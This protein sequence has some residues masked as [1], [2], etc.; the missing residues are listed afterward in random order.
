MKYPKLI[1]DLTGDAPVGFSEA[2]ALQN[3]GA[4]FLTVSGPGFVARKQGQ[5]LNVTTEQPAATDFK[6]YLW[7][8]YNTA[9]VDTAHP[10]APANLHYVVADPKKRKRKTLIGAAPAGF[11]VSTAGL[12]VGGGKIAMLRYLDSSA[13]PIPLT[14]WMPVATEKSA[15]EESTGSG[16]GFARTMFATGWDASSNSWRYGFSTR[17]VMDFSPP[18]AAELQMNYR[19]ASYGMQGK[20]HL[21]TNPLGT[22]SAVAL[23]YEGGNRFQFSSGVFCAGPGKLISLVTVSDHLTIAAGV[24]TLDRVNPFV[25]TSDDHGQSWSRATADFLTPFLRLQLDP[26]SDNRPEVMGFDQVQLMGLLSFFQYIGGGKTLLFVRSARTGWVASPAAAG[27]EANLCFIWDGSGFS[28]L[29]W[30]F[31]GSSRIPTFGY[32]SPLPTGSPPSGGWSADRRTIAPTSYCFG[33]GCC[34]IFAVGDFDFTTF[35][36]PT[37]LRITRDF[38]ATWSEVDVSNFSTAF[39]FITL[40]PYLSPEKPGRIL[41]LKKR[42]GGTDCYQTT[43]EFASFVNLGPVI[44]VTSQGTRETGVFVGKRKHLY[45]ELP[46]EFNKP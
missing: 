41:F 44:Q 46:N 32:D 19:L 25:L 39:S 7:H 2:R 6:P 13:S 20:A 33:P 36:Y 31:D 15:A 24:A 42:A 37:F 26:Y 28:R 35:R 27:D 8:A 34:A 18:V 30:G 29:A 40:S 11:Y 3:T 12:Y 1:G 45:P 43:G 14:F 38:G 22:T 9:A 21:S 17:P 5:F 23:P 10:L 16:D 4:P